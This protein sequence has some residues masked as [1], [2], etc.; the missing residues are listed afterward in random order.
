MEIFLYAY[1]KDKELVLFS[2]CIPITRTDF[3]VKGLKAC[4]FGEC[5][6]MRLQ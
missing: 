4:L 6:D 3:K 1:V 2:L 5:S